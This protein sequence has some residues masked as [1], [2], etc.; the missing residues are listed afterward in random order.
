MPALR[1][2]YPEMASDVKVEEFRRK[3]RY[4]FASCA[5]GFTTRYMGDHV[6]V[7]RRDGN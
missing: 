1:A 7:Y 2:T 4:Y 6:L 3:W 5:S